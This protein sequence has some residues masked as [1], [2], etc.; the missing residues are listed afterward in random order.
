MRGKTAEKN[1]TWK[2][3]KQ[4]THGVLSH[5]FAQDKSADDDKH[6]SQKGCVAHRLH[7]IGMGE[8]FDQQDPN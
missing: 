4:E 2:T 7:L 3:Q 8:W 5:L 1:K 6:N